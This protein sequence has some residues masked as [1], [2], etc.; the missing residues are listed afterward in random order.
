MLLWES[1]WDAMKPTILQVAD[2]VLNPP[3]I[4]PPAQQIFKQKKLFSAD[5]TCE[6][7]LP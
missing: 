6:V 2:K 4:S 5:F 7:T 3:T 1:D